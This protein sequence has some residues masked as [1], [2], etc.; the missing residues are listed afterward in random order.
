MSLNGLLKIVAVASTIHLAHKLVDEVFQ[1]L[2]ERDNKHSLEKFFQLNDSVMVYRQKSQ[3]R[4]S[5]SDDRTSIDSSSYTDTEPDSSMA[6]HWHCDKAY[7]KMVKQMAK[8]MNSQE[9]QDS[10]DN[11]ENEMDKKNENEKQEN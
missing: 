11:A 1:Y 3:E 10:K 4:S 9:S 7:V 5:A 6:R 2:R 8:D